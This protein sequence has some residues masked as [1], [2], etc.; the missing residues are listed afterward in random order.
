MKTL[1]LRFAGPMQSWG[2]ESHFTNRGTADWP[3]KSGVIGMIAS[4]MGRSREESVSDLCKL[5]MGVRIDRAGYRSTDYHIVRH[6]KKKGNGTETTQTMRDY[7]F[8]AIFL[9]GVCSDDDSLIES[10]SDALLHPAHQL[11]LGRRACAP[12]MPLVLK[13][14]EKNLLQAL[15][16]EEWQVKVD[17]MKWEE[18]NSAYSTSASEISRR[19]IIDGSLLKADNNSVIRDVPVSYSSIH[20]K[21]S[22]RKVEELY[23]TIPTGISGTVHG[24]HGIAETVQDPMSQL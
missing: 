2:F 11:Y 22:F 17:S 8:D 6:M 23:V 21:Y 9:V 3:T 12:G 15:S 24:I 4:A 5:R 7:L 1:L 20:R 14:T 18:V 13:T 10:V 16:D 19:I